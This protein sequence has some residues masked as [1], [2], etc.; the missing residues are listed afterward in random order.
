[1]PRWEQAMKGAQPHWE[2]FL[3]LEFFSYVDYLREYFRTGDLTYKQLFIGEKIKSLYDAELDDRAA[4]ERTALVNHAEREGLERVLRP[5]L[6][7]DNWS[8]FVNEIDF[9]HRS[10][11]A[12]A[13]RVQRVLLVGDCIF[14]DIIP[15]VVVD[16]LAQG[17]RLVFDYATSKN[18]FALRDE[19]RALSAK[20]FDLVFI[21][22]FS[23]EFVAAYSQLASL[24]SLRMSHEV[25]QAAIEQTWQTTRATL[26][27]AAELFDCPIHVHN[28]AAIV[29]EEHSG[30][31]LLRMVATSARR[32]RGRRYMNR[33]LDEY[34]E[35]KNGEAFRHLFVLHEDRCVSEFGEW[36]AGAFYH[37]TALQHPAAMGRALAPHY[38]DILYANAHLM[39]RKLVVCDLDGTLWEGMIGEGEVVHHHLRQQALRDLKTKGVVLAIASKNDPANVHWRGATLTT[40]DFVHAAISWEPKVHAMKRIQADLNLKSR[41]FIFIDDR[42]D[43]LSMMQTAFPE[44]LCLDANDPAT[45]RRIGL[46]QHLLDGD[47]EMDRTLMYQ[48]RDARKGFV[49]EDSDSE[50]EKANL[51]ASLQLKVTIAHATRADLKRITELVNRTNQFNLQATRTSFREVAQWHQ[52]SEHVILVAQTS[53]RFGDMGATCIAIARTKGDEMVLM[54]FVLSCR[55][56]GYGVERS[57]LNYLK[58]IAADEGIDRLV[59]RYIETPQNAPC[60]DFL[61]DNGFHAEGDRWVFQIGETSPTDPAWLQVVWTSDPAKALTLHA[62]D[63][64]SS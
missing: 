51:F 1:M 18:P 46:W 52:S 53:D 26:D 31:R 17:V 11:S 23:Y 36:R 56:F 35:Q 45:W 14:L 13:R 60:R 2:Q 9:V 10:L 38:V 22:P 33:A 40:N 21:S 61:P 42:H 43:E 29:R 48:Q 37:R 63:E 3:Q 55:V 32:K 8:S 41:N 64:R 50:I 49:A 6:S 34:V 5:H 28:S 62:E 25:T 27:V 24:R 47:L 20:S 19:L 44:V 57:V 39:G 54:A 59:G 12:E 16:L 7:T 58:S 30:K 4:R 15:F